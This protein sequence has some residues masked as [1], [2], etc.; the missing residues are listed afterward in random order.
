MGLRRS[1][2]AEFAGFV[3]KNCVPVVIT[4]GNQI[5]IT[6]ATGKVL[7]AP[8]D[9]WD[10][11][12]DKGMKEFEALPEHERKPKVTP[13]GRVYRLPPPPNGLV[14][15]VYTRGLEKS[16]DRGLR[17]IE[18]YSKTYRGPQRDFLWLTEQEWRSLV[19]QTTAPGER[20]SVPGPVATRLFCHH[21]VNNTVGLAG[22]MSPSNVRRSEITLVVEDVSASEVRLRVEGE[23]VVANHEEDAKATIRG[24]FAI[25]GRG[26][27]DRAKGAFSRLEMVALGDLVSDAPPRQSFLEQGGRQSLTLGVAFEIATPGSVGYGS[28]PYGLWAGVYSARPGS[29][30]V[31]R[32]FGS[33]PYK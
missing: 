6:T 12:I 29:P 11:N 18:Q 23:A 14:L 7:G 1:F 33:D 20:V 15:R 5:Q 32:Y 16:E 30:E 25:E 21:L 26:V 10:S 17:R 28:V 2:G 8:K 4:G 24:R 13:A 9:N 27:I 3:T 22:V 19:P 31:L